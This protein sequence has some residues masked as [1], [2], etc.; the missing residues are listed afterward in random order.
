MGKRR[1]VAMVVALIGLTCGSFLRAPA[2]ARPSEHYTGTH[3][4]AGNLPPGCIADMSLDN[5]DNKCFHMRTEMNALDSPQVD[6][7]VL[8]PVSPTAERDMRIMRQ[9]VEMW[10][11]GIH[12]MAREMGLGWLSDGMQFHVTL[13]YMDPTGNQGG[14]FTTYPVVDPEIVVVATNPV[15]GAGIGI[16]PVATAAQSG[17]V[18][19]FTD[20]NGVPCHGIQNP[21]D[22]QAWENLPGFN[23]HHHQRTGTYVEDCGGAGG[24]T[25]FAINGAID[26]APDKLDF[27]GL[28]DLVSHEFGH[29]LT[30][31]HVGDGAEGSWG[32]LPSNDI[33]AYSQD[34]PGGTKCVSSLD[35][36]GI[37]VRMSKYLDVNG[38]GVVDASDKLQANDQVGD[39]NNAFQVQNPRDHVYASSTG[40]P[41][42][43]P[44]PDVGLVPGPRT[45]WTPTPVNTTEPTLDVTSPRDGASSS[46]GHLDVTGTVEHRALNPDPVPTQATGSYDDPD[47]DASTP[48][49]E[50]QSLDVAATPTE[51]DATIHLADLWPS[52][53]AASP[54]SYSLVVDGRK[55]DSFVRYPI[56]H[57]P[58]TFDNGAA[59]Y[60]AEGDGGSSWDLEAKTVSFHLSRDYLAKAGITSPYFVSSQA[61]LG[62]LATTAPD[63]FAPDSKHPAVG[64]AA[65]RVVRPSVVGTSVGNSF[66]TVTFEHDGGN[67]YFP[68]DSTLGI[69]AFVYDPG[70]RHN[71][72]LDVPA[73]SDVEFNLTWT[74]TVGGTDLD[75]RVTGAANSG[76]DGASSGP[77]EHFVMHG[78]KGLLHLEV[79]PYMVTDPNGST[80][81]LTATTTPSGGGVDT[82]GDGVIDADD[83]CP[84]TPGTTATGCPDRDGDGVADVADACPDAAGTGRDGCPVAATEHVR[85]Y[86]DDVLT[87][88]Q[89]VD[90]VDGPDAFAIPV[91]VTSGSHVLRVD[92]EDRGNVIASQSIDVSGPTA[93]AGTASTGGAPGGS[94][95]S[96]AWTPVLPQLVTAPKR[97]I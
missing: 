45:Q 40:S 77:S 84:D 58:M 95:A 49:T 3:F 22:F 37:A 43:C 6:V 18:P 9:S 94:T 57:N 73:T 79:D 83:Q 16:D 86:V 39:G 68:E 42:D 23:D 36:E 47:D 56:D 24:N 64:V 44:Q 11:A 31:G 25:C 27:F 5:P 96:T 50:I 63:D 26:P 51:V 71:Y 87:G 54:T 76:S 29:C 46:D 28:F 66:G 72:N 8:V 69:P 19:V 80:Y 55:F 61:N 89:D 75:M 10:E 91:D 17:A 97:L 59:G 15:G 81:T 85:V 21:F 62:S 67:T 41:L 65:A 92:W 48:I 90:T 12:F 60:V 14:E 2:E 52:T 70:T 78:V 88:S 4:G 32:V 74:D 13:D 1:V 53:D 20:E 34:P 33:M 38:D 35:V 7:L 93:P 30:I 82:D